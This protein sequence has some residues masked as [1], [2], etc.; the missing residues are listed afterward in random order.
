MA[1]EKRIDP[2]DGTA[3]TWEE[4]NAYYKGQKYKKKEIESYWEECTVMKKK[5][6]EG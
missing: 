4:F 3:Y 2:D 6:G 1:E 5:K